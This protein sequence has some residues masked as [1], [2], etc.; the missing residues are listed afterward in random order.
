M[1]REREKTRF[2]P[3]VPSN[4]YGAT[5]SVYVVRE[6]VLPP[7][8]IPV[9][10]HLLPFPPFLLFLD[11]PLAG[12]PSYLLRFS[13][14]HLLFLLVLS[15]D[16]FV[17]LIGNGGG[18]LFV[19]RKGRRTIAASLLAGSLKEGPFAFSTIPFFLQFYYTY[20]RYKILLDSS[21]VRGRYNCFI[22]TINITK[23]KQRLLYSSSFCTYLE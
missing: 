16:R 18:G 22:S 17:G 7:S 19:T 23:Q 6:G 11:T 3:R 10:F 9:F 14:F 1:E 12:F 20:L 13:I 4:R 21:R 8:S 2:P 5:H 15:S